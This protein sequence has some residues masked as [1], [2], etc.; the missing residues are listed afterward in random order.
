MMPNE[1]SVPD[2]Q[3][4][5]VDLNHLNS[6]T[7]EAFSTMKDKYPNLYSAHKHHVGKFTGW[8]AKAVINTAINCRQKQH[9][10]F[11]PQLQKMILTYN[12][13]REYLFLVQEAQIPIY[14]T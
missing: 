3:E 5:K 9:G 1:D 4:L 12:L 13:E 6:E 8:H 2:N 11:L 10:R 7:A 14:T